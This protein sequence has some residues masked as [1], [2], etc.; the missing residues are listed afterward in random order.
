MTN[1]VPGSLLVASRWSDA[2][3]SSAAGP[4][5]PGT[6]LTGAGYIAQFRGGRWMDVCV[7][8]FVQKTQRAVDDSSLRVDALYWSSLHPMSAVSAAV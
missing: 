4:V 7:G 3:V 5:R 1:Y 6:E 2:T 8:L